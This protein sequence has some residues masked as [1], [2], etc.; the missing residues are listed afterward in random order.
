M[1]EVLRLGSETYKLNIHPGQ[2]II[3]PGVCSFIPVVAAALNVF[4][5]PSSTPSLGLQGEVAAHVCRIYNDRGIAEG[6]NILPGK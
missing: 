5:V 6:V 3:W 1:C 2:V 4:S